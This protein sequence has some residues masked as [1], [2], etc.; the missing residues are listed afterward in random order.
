[1]VLNPNF[2]LFLIFFVFILLQAWALYFLSI[3]C[4]CRECLAKSK[5]EE[6]MERLMIVK[7]GQNE[8]G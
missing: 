3:V 2:K 4:I 7:V 1:V 6:R 5:L 8:V